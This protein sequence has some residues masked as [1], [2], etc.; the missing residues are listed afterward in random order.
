MLRARARFPRPPQILGA[1]ALCASAPAALALTLGNIEVRSA[2]GEPLDARIPVSASAGEGLAGACFSLAGPVTPGAPRLSDATLG[3][4][5]SAKGAYLRVR[6]RGPMQEPA[7]LVRIAIACPHQPA[8]ET[9]SYSILLDPRRKLSS[10]IVATS[11]TVQPGDTLESIASAIFRRDRGA[12]RDY[13]EA[14]R[15]ANPALAA[16]GDGDPIAAGSVIALPDLRTFARSRRAPA[17][18]RV[19]GPAAQAGALSGVPTAKPRAVQPAKVVARLPAH[20]PRTGLASAAPVRASP[21]AGFQLKLSAAVVDLSPSRTIDDRARAQLRERLAVLDADDQM[22][23]MLSMRNSLHQLEAEVQQLR[24]KLAQMPAALAQGGPAPRTSAP[25]QAAAPP[26][27]QPAAAIRP[28]PAPAALPSG[29]PVPPPGVAPAP[30]PAAAPAPP[31]HALPASPPST[32][33]APPAEAPATAPSATAREP[34]ATA[35]PPAETPATASSATAKEPT[36]TAKPPAAAPAAMPASPKAA[37]A[38]PSMYS[39]GLWAGIVV[40]LMLAALAVVYLLRRRVPAAP[41]V[42]ERRQEPE[43]EAP[44]DVAPERAPFAEEPLAAREA[45]RVEVASDAELAT[46]I[47]QENADELRRRYMEERFPE[48]VNRTIALED[49]DSVVK[50]ARL[51]YED[52]ALP[53][54]VELLH[55]AIEGNPAEVRFWLAL[56]EIFRLERLTGEF[57]ELAR[58]FRE[59]HGKSPEWHKVQY[60]GREIDPGNRLYQDER[61]SSLETIGPREAQRAAETFDPLAENWLNAPMDFDNEVLANELRNALMVEASLTEQDLVPNPM[62]ALRSVEMFTVA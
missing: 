52:G 60:F 13:L 42:E 58:R 37:V 15:E 29:P 16:L 39:Y 5:R 4:R 62:P 1:I 28:V 38:T 27:S 14:M 6:S 47:P 21:T 9:R 54:A 44:M 48:T 19:P 51:F 26:G 24:L 22:A 3:L 23:A 34:T 46:R 30:R 10:P 2:L 49:A 61:F 56:F 45:P 59:M 20:A 55:F 43:P 57:A 32:P 41:E 33:P 17:A 31:P 35:K 36:A 8:Q 40:V 7:I 25:T 18:A 53:R 50:G 11:F 12:R